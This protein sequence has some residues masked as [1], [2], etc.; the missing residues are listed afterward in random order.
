VT[1]INLQVVAGMPTNTA[2]TENTVDLSLART[3]A[4]QATQT[5]PTLSEYGL[6]LLS[7]LIGAAALRSVQQNPK[8]AVA[9]V[10]L[11]AVLS[12]SPID[13]ALAVTTTTPDGW[14]VVTVDHGNNGIERIRGR[15]NGNTLEWQVIERP[16]NN[17]I[18]PAT[19]TCTAD[20]TANTIDCGSLDPAT[21]EVSTDN[22]VSWS[23]FSSSTTYD[24]AQIVL[25]R[26]KA[27]GVNP[28]SDAQTFNFTENYVMPTLPTSLSAIGPVGDNGGGVPLS[29]SINM[30]VLNDIHGN[31]IPYLVNELPATDGFGQAVIWTVSQT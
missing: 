29:F 3:F 5:I 25:V 14:T 23:A 17:S 19:P 1:T 4:A 9:L 30:P 12:N 10:A 16:E 31:Q 22:G 27:I 2:Y 18:K 13:P 7:L 8:K 24:G 11:A 20:D 15:I 6:I 28:V 21:L 26:V